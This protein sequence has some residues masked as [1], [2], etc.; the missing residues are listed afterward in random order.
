MAL[1]K[2]TDAAG[3]EAYV[4]TASNM[5]Y[6]EGGKNPTYYTKDAWN[7]RQVKK[8]GTSNINASGGSTSKSVTDM[9]AE[10]TKKTAAEETKFTSSYLK[11]NPFAFDENLARQ[12][13]T[14]EYDP[15]YNEILSDYVSDVNTQKGT[16]QDQQALTQKMKE[17]DLGAKSRE[18]AKAVTKTEEGYV[19]S[20]LYFSGQKERDLGSMEV[21]NQ[22]Q[23]Q[24]VLDQY[25][26][27]EK[28]YQTQLGTLD[29]Q[30]E[31]KARDVER[32]KK[33]SVEAGIATR[34]GEAEKSYYN[35]LL[36]NYYRQFPT[37][38]GGALKGY[39]PD[40]YLRY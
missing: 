15:Y 5:V 22:A 9:L 16:I 2:F 39:L 3:R 21:E 33:A 37:S 38:S 6:T 25:G 26:Y 36:S 8:Y 1:Q 11:K 12:S 18:Y 10:I 29:T 23:T 24:N 13:A 20:G 40:E 19:G 14:A 32:E 35:T 30:A 34:Q 27:K 17:Y 28:G 4:D 31:R 7:Q